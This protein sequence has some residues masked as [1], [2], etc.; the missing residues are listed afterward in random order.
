L[1]VFTFCTELSIAQ[2]SLVIFAGAAAAVAK[3]SGYVS[4]LE[5]HGNTLILLP[6]TKAFEL[7]VTF[8]SL[9]QYTKQRPT[10]AKDF[11][12]DTAKKNGRT[13]FHLDANDSIGYVDPPKPSNDAGPPSQH[14]HGAMSLGQGY[15]TFTLSFE[16]NAVEHT[17]VRW[18][19]DKGLL[20]LL[21]L[22]KN[23]G[24]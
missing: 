11:I 22:L 21:A 7:R 9:A 20:E 4:K 2:S 14:I 5:E 13:L 15:A 3:P 10:I 17:D 18:A 19:R 8:H 24:A 16:D 1:L 12:S 23:V 6:A